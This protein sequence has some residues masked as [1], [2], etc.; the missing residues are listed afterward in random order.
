[1]VG[2]G[3]VSRN[4]AR[5]PTLGHDLVDGVGATLRVPAVDDYL[6]AQGRQLQ[7]DGSP[8]PAVA[9]VTRAVDPDSP[10]GRVLPP[11]STVKRHEA[12]VAGRANACRL[13]SGEAEGG[14]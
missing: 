11:S 13:A 14:T 2:V 4:K 8:I 9:P 6:G 3:E 12:S 10:T 7:G 5:P 1:M